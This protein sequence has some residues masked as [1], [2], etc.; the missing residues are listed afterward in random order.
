[1]S[2]DVRFAAMMP[3]SRAAPSTS[4]FLAFPDTIR[5]SVALLMITRPS[6]AAVR[7]VAGFADTSTIRASPLSSMW[8]RE[9]RPFAFLPAMNLPGSGG[10][11]HALAG[12]Q[13]PRGGGDIR[14]SHQA[15]ADKERRHAD[16]RQ[17]REVDG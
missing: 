16:T 14:L 9:V 6:A 5:S 15:F 8:V 7:S 1:M 4:P 17:P 13:C 2:S 11:G 12:Q 3:A 10:A